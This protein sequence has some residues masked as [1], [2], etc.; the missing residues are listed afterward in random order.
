MTEIVSGRFALGLIKR[1]IIL[2]PM[3]AIGTAVFMI[4]SAE[5]AARVGWT[6]SP[7]NVCHLPGPQ[8][9]YKNCTEMDKVPESPSVKE[10]YNEC[11]YRSNGPCGPLSEGAGRIAVV[12][13]S[14]SWAHLVP[15]EDAWSV[16]AME[17]LGT[18]CKYIPNVQ[19]LG[20]L[21]TLNDVAKRLPEAIE[22][23]PQLVVLAITPFDVMTM[24]KGGFD[25][26]P[27]WIEGRTT[28]PDIPGFM[29]WLKEQLA[30]SRVVVV[31]QHFYFMNPQK[32]VSTYLQYGD[33]A[34]FLRQPFTPA[35]QDRLVYIDNALKYMGE[36][37]SAN[38]IP[39]MVVNIPHQT[40]AD[41]VGAEL[42]FPAVDARALGVSI[43]KIA[44]KYHIYYVDGLEAFNGHADAPDYYYNVDGHLNVEGNHLLGDMVNKSLASIQVHGLCKPND[45][46]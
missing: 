12:G 15:F 44:D 46:Q 5:L 7:H 8:R 26:N 28:R 29:E 34:D 6:E 1:D 33:K 14:A 3:V 9:P 30:K 19:S 41:I 20:G 21:G 45:A 2:L 38:H 25:P 32:Y 11:G 42:R 43:Q 13:S 35:W 37:L 36:K 18:S 4:A 27:A 10:S 22:L 39:F 16:K 40:Q 17:R 24:P 31:S 23:R